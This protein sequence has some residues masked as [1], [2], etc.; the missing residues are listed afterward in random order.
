[1]VLVVPGQGDGAGWST[2]GRGEH[3]LGTGTPGREGQRYPPLLA[4]PPPWGVHHHH[5]P[6][7]QSWQEATECDLQSQSDKEMSRLGSGTE[8]PQQGEDW[9]PAVSLL[10]G[11]EQGIQSLGL[12]LSPIINLLY[13]KHEVHCPIFYLF[14]F[15]WNGSPLAKTDLDV[16]FILVGGE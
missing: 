5:L 2:R 12:I 13:S 14:I 15:F 1:M 11:N 8:P 7:C 6:P 4:T 10:L 9:L 16:N 3:Q